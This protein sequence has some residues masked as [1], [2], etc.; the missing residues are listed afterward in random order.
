MENV[1]TAEGASYIPKYFKASP[2]LEQF[3]LFYVL[4]KGNH[5]Q[6]NF[7][8]LDMNKTEQTLVSL[9]YQCMLRVYCMIWLP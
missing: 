6:S 1:S 9:I 4:L 8:L 2:Q 3:L 7:S 5:T